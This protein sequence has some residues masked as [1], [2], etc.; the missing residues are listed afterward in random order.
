MRTNKY[1]SDDDYEN[2][3]YEIHKEYEKIKHFKLEDYLECPETYKIINDEWN[4]RVIRNMENKI[5]DLFELYFNDFKDVPYGFMSRSEMFHSTDLLLLIK[6]HLIRNYTT[7]M[8]KDKPE[9]A[10][11]LINSMKYIKQQRNFRKNELLKE[12]FK[13]ANTDFCWNKVS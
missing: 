11:P 10:N 1:N 13:K 3:D 5:T 9:L 4:E 8:F 6:H 7:D 12:K 2:D